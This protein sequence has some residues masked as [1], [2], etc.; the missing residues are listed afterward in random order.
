MITSSMSNETPFSGQEPKSTFLRRN[1]IPNFCKNT[2]H[3]LLQVLK[4]IDIEYAFLFW[5]NYE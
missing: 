5:I 2:M 4:Y 3:V 1:Y